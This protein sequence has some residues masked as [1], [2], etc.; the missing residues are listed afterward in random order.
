MLKG[1]S[2]R[3]SRKLLGGLRKM[4]TLQEAIDHAREVASGCNECAKEHGQL[5][6]WLEEL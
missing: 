5:A 4:M 6:D 3:R 1:A 2:K